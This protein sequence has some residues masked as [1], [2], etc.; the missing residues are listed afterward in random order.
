MIINGLNVR[1]YR[2]ASQ[3]TLQYTISSYKVAVK[4]VIRK[5]KSVSIQR[6]SLIRIQIAA[7]TMPVP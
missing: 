7:K 6:E 3:L 2:D 1:A 4:Q 5:L